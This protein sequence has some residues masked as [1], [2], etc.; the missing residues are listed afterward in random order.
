MH[1]AKK[2]SQ[3]A[4][5]NFLP[6]KKCP[7]IGAGQLIPPFFRTVFGGFWAKNASVLIGF[8]NKIRMNLNDGAIFLH[9]VLNLEITFQGIFHQKLVFAQHQITT[10]SNTIL[11]HFTH[12]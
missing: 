1:G 5:G 11:V 3:R 6:L 8:W 10:A 7:K 12:R 4:L 9:L 2:H